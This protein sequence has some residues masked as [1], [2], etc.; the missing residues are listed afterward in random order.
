MKNIFYLF[1]II[2]A[3]APLS[4]YARID[5]QEEIARNIYTAS[6]R[7]KYNDQNQKLLKIEACLKDKKNQAYYDAMHNTWGFYKG[8]ITI[9][10]E[11]FF[12]VWGSKC[13]RIGRYYFG[14]SYIYVYQGP[15]GIRNKLTKCPEGNKQPREINWFW[16]KNELV[17]YSQIL[18]I[19]LSKS[20]YQ[21]R[22]WVE[23]IEVNYVDNVF[24][25]EDYVRK[26]L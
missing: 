16:E 11:N 5:Y 22:R 9:V 23:P 6:L 8:Q 4:S 19:D 2:F 20:R 7:N 26:C 15:N 12:E 3:F 10:H 24:S 25:R 17:K 21:V 13:E 18:N 14:E 1:F